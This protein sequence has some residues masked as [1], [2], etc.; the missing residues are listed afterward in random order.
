MLAKAG[1]LWLVN[2]MADVDGLGEYT[3]VVAVGD[4]LAIIV[5]SNKSNKI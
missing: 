1:G 3:D 2:D 5:V 4:T